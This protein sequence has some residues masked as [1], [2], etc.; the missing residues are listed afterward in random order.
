[1]GYES[2]IARQPSVSAAYRHLFPVTENLV[3]L[4]HAAVGPLSRR[5]ADAMKALAD[6]ALM[7]GS[8]HY[9]QWL[10]AYE[11]V[12]VASARLINAGKSEIAIVKNTS[13]GIAAIAAGLEWRP[14]DKVVAFREEFP[15]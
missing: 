9:D 1:M 3:Y 2:L 15:A 7:Y 10:D 13:E 12:R 14:G 6:D 4:N 5:S 11:G 8:Y